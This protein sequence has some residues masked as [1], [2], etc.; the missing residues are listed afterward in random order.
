ML[1]FSLL[2][3][4]TKPPVV[5]FAV[6]DYNPVTDLNRFEAGTLENPPAFGCPTALTRTVRETGALAPRCLEG[7]AKAEN[8]ECVH[9]CE[10]L[11]TPPRP[12]ATFADSACT[13]G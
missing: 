5:S 12:P 13:R 11:I 9:G 6:C 2:F 3:C 7:A 10:R 8:C 4:F 1:S